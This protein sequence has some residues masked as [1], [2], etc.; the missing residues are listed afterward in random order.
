LGIQYVL[1]KQI[2]NTQHV[3]MSMYAREV[4]EAN[5]QKACWRC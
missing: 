2:E 1:K 4:Q 5:P 3:V